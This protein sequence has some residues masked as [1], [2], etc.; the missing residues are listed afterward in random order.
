[1]SKAR[2]IIADADPGYIIPLQLKFV[3][4]FF[5]RVDIEIITEKELFDSLFSTPQK[6]DIVIVSEDLYDPSLQRHNIGNIF[7]MMEQYEDGQTE[8][9]NITKLFKYTSI[10]EIFN[11]IIGKSAEFLKIEKKDSEPQIIMVYS[12]C[13]GA[14]KTT[15]SLGICGCL[16]LNYKKVLYINASYLQSFQWILDNATPVMD[17]AVYAKLASANETIYHDIKHV[18]R[19]ELFNYLPPFKAAIMSLGIPFSIYE[20]IARS[21]KKANEYDYIVVDT[22][23]TFDEDKAKLMNTADKVIIVTEQTAASVFSTNLLASNINGINADKFAFVCNNFNK[24]LDNAIISPMMTMRFS[25]NEYV[26]HFEHYDRLK[27]DDFAKNS[28]I[29]KAT[30]LVL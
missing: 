25:I 9:L 26:E 21:A 3:E 22:D 14:G 28:S 29:Q 24:D 20:L 12:A 4:D 23:D 18:I 7:L 1:M 30:V 5:D 2:I 10:K 17:T 27:C 11:E 19:K 8:E 6:A 16:T 15:L 13:G